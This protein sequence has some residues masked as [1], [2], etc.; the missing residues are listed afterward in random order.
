MLWGSAQFVFTLNK[1][2][3][4]V[5]FHFKTFL[6]TFFFS[7]SYWISQNLGLPDSRFF[8]VV[9]I[10][11]TTQE[12]CTCFQ[13]DLPTVSKLMDFFKV[14]TAL[15]LLSDRHFPDRHLP[16]FMFPELQLPRPVRSYH[17]YKWIR[18]IFWMSQDLNMEK[19]R[20]F[21]Y[22]LTCPVR[23]PSSTCLKPKG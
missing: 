10:L 13:P 21:L 1:E 4:V 22:P 5:F 6:K 23:L 14:S 18:Y 3:Y 20:L 11:R 17:K 2:L 7:K 16:E 15:R 19:L 8:D 9:F 12:L